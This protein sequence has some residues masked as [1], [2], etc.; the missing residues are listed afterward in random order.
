MNEEVIINNDLPWDGSF[1]G[2]FPISSI[3]YK[4]KLERTVYY[5]ILMSTTAEFKNVLYCI[6]YKTKS[7]LPCIIDNIK[8]IFNIPKRGL[9][10]IILGKSTYIIFFVPITKDGE[11]VWETPLNRLKNDHFLRK[12]E[13]FSKKIRYMITFCDILSLS[14]TEEN[15]LRIRD[16]QTIINFNYNISLQKEKVYDFTVISNRLYNKWFGDEFSIKDTVKE[17]FN[18]EDL[19]MI[20]FDLREKIDEIIKKYDSNYIWY[21]YFIVDRVSRYL[22]NI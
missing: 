11:L 8:H 21:S 3:I 4:W 14:N 13:K 15:I 22:L 12:D 6:P 5:K 2:K 18:Y 1:I 19:D 9:H 7:K 16:K 10:Q 17:I 20:C